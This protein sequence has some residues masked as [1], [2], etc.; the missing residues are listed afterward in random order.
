MTSINE[1]LLTPLIAAVFGQP[2]FA[3]VGQF[4]INGAVF[5]P[6]IVFTQLL[7]FVLIAATIYFIV[8]A[9]LNRMAQR[10]KAEQPAAPPAGPTE[11]ELLTEIRDTLVHQRRD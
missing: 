2:N 1:A 7:N 3:T 11:V 9:P 10:R 5:S 4:T 6:G 8:V